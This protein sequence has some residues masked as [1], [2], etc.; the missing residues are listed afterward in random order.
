VDGW[1]H[2]LHLEQLGAEPTNGAYLIFYSCTGVDRLAAKYCCAK[3]LKHLRDFGKRAKP[4][5]VVF[6][7]C[8]T[9][10]SVFFWKLDFWV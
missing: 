5:L 9:S 10:F 2:L 6:D 7:D 4:A 1:E 3:A 8:L